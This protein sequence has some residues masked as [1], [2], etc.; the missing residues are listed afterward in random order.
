MSPVEIQAG[1][2]PKSESF[3]I[4]VCLSGDGV[5]SR[6]GTATTIRAGTAGVCNPGEMLGTVAWSPGARLLGVALPTAVVQQKLA[7]LLGRPLGSELAAETA[8]NIDSAAGADWLHMVSAA[9][10]LSLGGSGGLLGNP[11]L[12]Y[13]LED[14]LIRGFLYASRHNY[15]EHLRRR[16]TD[17][18]SAAVRSV[19]SAIEQ[20]A[21]LPLTVSDLAREAHIS[22][23]ALQESFNKHLGTSPMAYLRDVRI[24]RAHAEL[25]ASG[26]ATAT[27][28]QVAY[29]WG[30]TNVG[31]FAERYRSIFG[32]PP[33]RTLKNA[34]KFA[35]NITNE[36]L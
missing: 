5:S 31:R 1:N 16:V 14:W 23:R 3:N 12:N 19:M 26:G 24:R 9:S 33:H 35:Q 34:H 10:R 32:E 27:V 13:P 28:T 17:V 18:G 20:K 15:S 30:F 4:S 25:T 2:G 22:V 8:L 29:R 36:S 21:E 11:M 7:G 6:N